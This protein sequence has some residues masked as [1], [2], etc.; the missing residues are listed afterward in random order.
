MFKINNT[1]GWCNEC[2]KVKARRKCKCNVFNTS[3]KIFN[4]WN[5]HLAIFTSKYATPHS[6]LSM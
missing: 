5:K 3:E 6:F 4:D 2:I 1:V